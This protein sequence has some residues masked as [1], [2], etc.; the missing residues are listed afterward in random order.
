MIPSLLRILFFQRMFFVC[1]PLFKACMLTGLLF[2]ALNKGDS[3]EFLWYWDLRSGYQ[4]SS[5]RNLK[6]AADDR[7]EILLFT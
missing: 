2:N 6:P 5:G 1:Q 3:F 7:D 4:C